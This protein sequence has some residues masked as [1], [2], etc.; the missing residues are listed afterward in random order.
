MSQFD[1]RPYILGD[2]HAILDLFREC[3]PGRIMTMDYWQCR[4]RDNPA[5][6]FLIELAWDGEQ[7]AGHYAVSPV[8]MNIQGKEVLGGLSVT[9]MTHP[10]YRGRGLFPVLAGR[11]YRRMSDL[12]Y[13][14]VWGFPNE[15]SHEGFVNKLGW[16]DICQIPMLRLNLKDMNYTPEPTKG[17]AELPDFDGRFNR[18]WESVSPRHAIAVKRDREYLQWRFRTNP[19]NRYH[20]LGY[21]DKGRLLGYSIW[22]LYQGKELEIVDLLAVD[23][24][25]A[26]TA[27]VAAAVETGVRLGAE[28]IKTWLPRCSSLRASLE[29]M[30]F[31]EGP[32]LVYCGARP[33]KP[34]PAGADWFTENAWFYSMS[35]SD[36]F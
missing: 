26:G 2:E 13:L 35:D 24:E 6:Q 8:W 5:G 29:H 23:Q 4:F 16:R 21:T 25:S 22:K 1:Y 30:G 14:M 31:Q 10:D 15:N 32:P 3:F 28:S 9:T 11:L 27:L 33:L 7:L 19:I 20:L 36:V 34:L 12:G 18:L 17:V